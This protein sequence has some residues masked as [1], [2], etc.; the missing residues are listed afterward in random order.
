MEQEKP[1]K[2]V[3]LV[4]CGYYS[5]YRVCAVF[6][7]KLFAEKYIS[8][9]NST[10]PD[11]ELRIETYVLNPY[12]YELNKDYKP[13]SLRMT[14]EGICTEINVEDSSYGLEGGNIR[15]GIDVDENMFI[16]IFARDEKHAIKIANEKRVQ[17]IQQNRFL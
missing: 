7:E 1:K 15:F 9:F 10:V 16:S 8:R 17:L 5:E 13:F 6:T 11:E 2:E 14:K 12:E 3:F 4:T